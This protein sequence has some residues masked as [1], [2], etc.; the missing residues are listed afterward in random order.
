MPGNA[1]AAFAPDLPGKLDKAFSLFL[2]PSFNHFSFLDRGLN[3]LPPDVPLPSTLESKASTKTLTAIP[4]AVSMEVIIIPCFQKNI[5]IFSVNETSLSNNLAII[6]LKL[7]IW[8]VSL[9]LNKSILSCLTDTS[10]FSLAIC[11]L[12][13]S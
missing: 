3:A 5:L 8:F 13:S 11:F 7:I 2:I 4:I 12:M 1:S 9:P 10:S 6:S